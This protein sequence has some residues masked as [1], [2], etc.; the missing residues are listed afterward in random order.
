MTKSSWIFTTIRC[1][2]IT[3]VLACS[4]TSTAP[5]PSCLPDVFADVVPPDT[6]WRSMI[7]AQVASVP[8]DTL[9]GAIIEYRDSVSVGDRAVLEAAAATI[10][11]EFIGFLRY[12]SV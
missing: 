7:R 8:A 11:Y 3:G 6:G 1:F 5:L 4:D 12:P 10:T 9:L 2:G